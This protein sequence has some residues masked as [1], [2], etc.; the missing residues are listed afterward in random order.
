MILTILAA[1][2]NVVFY[3]WLGWFIAG[4]IGTADQAIF[5]GCFFATGFSIGSFGGHAGSEAEMDLALRGVGYLLGIVAFTALL[6]HQRAHA[7]RRQP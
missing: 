6:I 3:G 2:G 7:P 4:R 5:A 1:A